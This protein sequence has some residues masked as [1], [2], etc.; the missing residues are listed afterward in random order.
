MFLQTVQLWRRV[1]AGRRRLRDR[2]LISAGV[3]EHPRGA[4]GRV[5]GVWHVYSALN[6]DAVRAARDHDDELAARR[7][8]ADGSSG[9][10]CWTRSSARRLSTSSQT[11]VGD[12]VSPIGGAARCWIAGRRRHARVRGALD[13][14]LARYGRPTRRRRN[15][16]RRLFAARPTGWQGISRAADLTRSGTVTAGS[17]SRA[18]PAASTCHSCTLSAAG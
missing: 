15:R 1:A 14:S 16:A 6:R 2:E 7:A 4:A 12:A 8:C 18:A 13:T 5:A 3:A 11:P 9:R 10:H 17:S